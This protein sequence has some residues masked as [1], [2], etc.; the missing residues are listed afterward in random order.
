VRVVAPIAAAIVALCL[1]V[2]PLVRRRRVP[3]STAEAA[4]EP[5]ANVPSRSGADPPVA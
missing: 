4:P 2:I 5:T 3:R 1:I